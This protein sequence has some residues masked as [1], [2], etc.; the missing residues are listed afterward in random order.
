MASTLAFAFNPR[1]EAASAHQFVKSLAAILKIIDAVD[2]SLHQG[3]QPNNWYIEKLESSAPTIRMYPKRNGFDTVAVIGAGLRE[4]NETAYQPPEHFTETALERIHRMRS[5]F[6]EKSLL[7]SIDVSV[8]NEL[9][10]TITGRTADN[11]KRILGE[12]YSNLGSIQGRL[13]AIDIHHAPKG[14]VWDR[15]SGAPVRFRFERPDIA[16]VKALVD[17]RVL[18]SGNV[19][20]FANGTPRAIGDVIGI[21]DASHD[22]HLPRAEFGA[23]SDPR[24]VESG[25]QG[26]LQ[27][28]WELKDN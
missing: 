6:G 2:Y 4:L 19:S 26:V 18:I 13:E 21:E 28:A 16:N 3:E 25:A 22:E 11:A 9:I 1:V 8:D 23:V 27:S 7:D 24:V 14:T 20:Y 5:M 15:L 10:T 17:R 12:G